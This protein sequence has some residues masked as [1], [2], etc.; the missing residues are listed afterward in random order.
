MA[1][2]DRGD[3][4]DDD[5]ATGPIADAE[6]IYRTMWE[7]GQDLGLKKLGWQAYVMQ[8]TEPGF[9]KINAYRCRHTR[10]PIWRPSSTPAP[11]PPSKG[12][13]RAMRHSRRRLANPITA[14][15]LARERAAIV[16]HGS[17]GRPRRAVSS[18]LTA[19]PFQAGD[20]VTAVFNQSGDVSCRFDKA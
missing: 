5:L 20:S 10:S 8:H 4:R 13:S 12:R 11:K 16:R 17:A 6:A 3:R 9:A 2:T 18:F 15:A 7:S 19:P 14:V 1:P